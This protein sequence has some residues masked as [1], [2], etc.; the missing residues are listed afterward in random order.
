MGC[1]PCP[2]VMPPTWHRSCRRECGG[3]CRGYPPCRRWDVRRAA[4]ASAQR[5]CSSRRSLFSCRT[6]RY[7][8]GSQGRQRSA[9]G[10]KTHSPCLDPRKQQGPSS[11]SK[12]QVTSCHTQCLAR[13][14]NAHPAHRAARAGPHL[15]E[16]L[17]DPRAC[18]L[19]TQNCTDVFVRKSRNT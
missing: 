11:A 7:L 10:P 16:R 4:V 19:H 18:E 13:M 2:S 12:G 1:Q 17:T 6:N 15:Q 5:R 3:S 8:E 9:A 14:A